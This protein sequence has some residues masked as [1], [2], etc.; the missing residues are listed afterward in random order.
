MVELKV[1]LAKVGNS[2]KVTIPKEIVETLKL[3]EGDI[4]RIDVKDGAIVIKK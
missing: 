4:V 3:K 1:R 2:M